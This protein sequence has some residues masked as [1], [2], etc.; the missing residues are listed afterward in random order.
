MVCLFVC[1]PPYIGDIH[2]LH[3]DIIVQVYHLLVVDVQQGQVKA[4]EVELQI[5]KHWTFLKGQLCI[6]L[7]EDLGTELT[8][9]NSSG[10]DDSG[11]TFPRSTIG[12]NSRILYLIPLSRVFSMYC[13]EDSNG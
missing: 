7:S 5:K 1:F 9:C 4:H 10:L 3:N 6:L 2:T 12:L 13:L 11:F 8:G